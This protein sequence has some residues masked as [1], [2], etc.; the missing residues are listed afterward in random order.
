[1][2]KIHRE[3][4]AAIIV[5]KDEKI[6]LGKK[7]PEEEGVYP[8]CWHIPGGGIE[9]DETPTQAV[10]REIGEETGIDI[11]NYNVELVD[12]TGHG[13]GFKKDRSSGEKVECDMHF[14]VYQIQ[15]EDQRSEQI[16]LHL[17]DD[18][19]SGIWIP[20]SELKNYQLTPPSIVLF[21]KLGWI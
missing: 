9:K 21:K 7:N 1:M 6:F 15:L 13:L 12:D 19:V 4:V 20:F 3:I 14:I 5:S 17:N 10:I 2:Q 18:L 8:D 11:S 16:E